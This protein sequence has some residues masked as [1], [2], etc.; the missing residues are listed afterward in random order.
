MWPVIPDSGIGASQADAVFAS[1]PQ[2]GDEPSAGQVRQAV[3]SA[4]HAF[5]YGGCAERVTL[6]TVRPQLPTEQTPSSRGAMAWQ[7]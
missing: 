4:I 1:G 7:R 5:G 2:R 6:L 3:T